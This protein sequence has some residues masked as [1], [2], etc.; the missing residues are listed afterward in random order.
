MKQATSTSCRCPC[1]CGHAHG[2]H[3]PLKCSFCRAMANFKKPE[4]PPFHALAAELRKVNVGNGF[5]PVTWGNL[6]AKM[7]FAVTELDEGLEGVQNSGADPL[8]E[9]LAD[10]AI[11]ILD[12]L[13]T[14]WP[15]EWSDR[16]EGLGKERSPSLHAAFEPAE[17]ALWRPLRMMSRAVEAW[18]HDRRSDVRI[19]LEL[20]FRE[21]FVLA[22]KLGFDLALEVQWKVQKNRTRGHLHGKAQSAG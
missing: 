2:K 14:L 15:G 18:R 21:L 20:A 6:P 8:N 1:E 12:M 22:W 5:D 11:R 19:G 10:T 16:T 4:T 3:A 13:E 9:E 7:M 17:V